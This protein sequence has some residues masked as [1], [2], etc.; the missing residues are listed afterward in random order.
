MVDQRCVIDREREGLTSKESEIVT[1]DVNDADGARTRA[2]EGV[3]M[4]QAELERLIR[5]ILIAVAT[6]PDIAEVVT[7]HLVNA[8]LAG[9]D[10]HGI[11]QIPGY[12]RQIQQG[13]LNPTARPTIVTE[14]TSTARVDAHGGWGMHAAHF[15]LQQAITKAQESGVGAVSLGN[16]PHIGRLGQYAEDAA[17]RGMVGLVTF[18]EGKPGEFLA[19][20]YGSS[21]RALSTN[22]I[23]AGVPTGDDS[24]FVVDFATTT[25]ANARTWIYKERGEPLPEGVALDAAGAPTTD[26]D[27]YLD[28]G[29]LVIFGEHKGYGLSL[30]TCLL[31]ALNGRMATEENNHLGGSF[32]LVVDVSAF[33]DSAA[34]GVSTRTFLNGIKSATPASGHQEVLV[35]GDIEFRQ[36][37]QRRR[38]GIPISRRVRDDIVQV[39]Q[40]LGVDYG[41]L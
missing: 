26:P 20:P 10:S 19:V 13:T 6:P 15:C 11:I 2:D 9:Y 39:C 4:D 8:S 16:S 37:T 5:S 25:I 32:F 24:P 3:I 18:G 12:L 33:M 27:A 22:P 29:S 36:R 14:K 31:G 30:L 21:Q 35:P 34:Y 40:S 23:A 38:S 1:S 41:K 17:A 28:G 7:R